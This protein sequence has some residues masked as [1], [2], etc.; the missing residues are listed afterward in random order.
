VKKSN[1]KTV[2]PQDEPVRGVDGLFTMAELRGLFTM[3]WGT[4]TP[5]I[6]SRESSA[7]IQKLHQIVGHPFCR[8]CTKAGSIVDTRGYLVCE[9][10]SKE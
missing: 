7:A 8:K 1:T 9:E 10:H 4:P 6:G 3:C 2:R 5:M